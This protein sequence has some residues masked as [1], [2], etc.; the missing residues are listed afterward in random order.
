[1]SREPRTV[2]TRPAPGGDDAADQERHEPATVALANLDLA[3]G[4]R[5]GDVAV[6]PPRTEVLT[7]TAATATITTAVWSPPN[8]S[9]RRAS[10]SPARWAPSRV[11]T[12]A[13]R[14]KHRAN[15]G[16]QNE[17]VKVVPRPLTAVQIRKSC[18]EGHR[19]SRTPTTSRAR[20]G[21]DLRRDE[22]TGAQGEHREHQVPGDLGAEAPHVLQTRVAGRW[23]RRSARAGATGSTPRR[24]PAWRQGGRGRRPA[25]PPSTP[26]RSGARGGGRTSSGRAARRCRS[27]TAPTGG[28]AGSRRGRTGT[29]DRR[30]GP[31]ARGSRSGRRSGSGAPGARRGRAAR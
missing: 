6:R 5:G 16:N 7:A 9:R 17:T 10:R 26:G 23:R 11:A 14:Q 1:M 21:P 20:A 28:R 30:S 31:R 24:R 19:R 27:A 12:R 8:A 18:G 29:P 4:E 25:G 13:P 3:L 2:T 15:D 22:E